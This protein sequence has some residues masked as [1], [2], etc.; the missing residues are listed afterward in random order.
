MLKMK[1]SNGKCALDA[2]LFNDADTF[3][4]F[5]TEEFGQMEVN[6]AFN[7]RNNNIDIALAYYPSVN[8]F[9]GEKNLQITITDYCRI[10]NM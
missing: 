8:E 7:A 4:S 10:K 6:N 1:V 3:V 5:I 2:L 9:R